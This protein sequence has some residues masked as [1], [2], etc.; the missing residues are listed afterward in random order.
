[1]RTAVTDANQL[2][3]CGWFWGR[4]TYMLLP[5][6]DYCWLLAASETSRSHLCDSMF[7]ARE[8][9]NANR[10]VLLGPSSVLTWIGR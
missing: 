3:V 6:V 4:N 7:V 9:A 10:R 1:M 2:K 5:T 8:L